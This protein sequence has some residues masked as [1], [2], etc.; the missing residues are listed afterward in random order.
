MKTIGKVV[1]RGTSLGSKW[2]GDSKV[3]ANR[4]IVPL[5]IKLRL[6]LKWVASL[7]KEGILQIVS[8]QH[9]LQDNEASNLVSLL[10]PQ[11]HKEIIVMKT[12]IRSEINALHSIRLLKSITTLLSQILL[13]SDLHIS[14]IILGITLLITI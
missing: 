14:T 10:T 11:S 5:F 8:T 7:N 3:I 13:R 6:E 4:R 1:T 9:H 2:K 12:S